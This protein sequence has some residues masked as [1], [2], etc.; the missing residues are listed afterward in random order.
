MCNTVVYFHLPFPC[1]VHTA[2]DDASPANNGTVASTPG[3]ELA[4][5]GNGNGGGGTG[6]REAAHRAWEAEKK[7]RRRVEALERRLEERGIELQAAEGQTAKAKDL[8]TRQ[9]DTEWKEGTESMVC[10]QTAY[11]SNLFLCCYM[12]EYNLDV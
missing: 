7:L 3:R 5:S 10:L 12:L 2:A 11:V 6:H 4:T 8:L 1:L 9:E